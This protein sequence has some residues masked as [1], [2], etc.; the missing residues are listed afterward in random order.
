[1]ILVRHFNQLF[2]SSLRF[3]ENMEFFEKIFSS[4]HYSLKT[5]GA[6]HNK[7]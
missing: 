1:M 4:N 2:G 6:D 5:A 7:K 3:L